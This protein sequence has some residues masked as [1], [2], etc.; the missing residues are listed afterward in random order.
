MNALAAEISAWPQIVVEV[1]IGAGGEDHCRKLGRAP[2][3]ARSG[4]GPI[5][6]CTPGKKRC[7]SSDV[8]ESAEVFVRRQV[9]VNTFQDM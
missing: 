2:R 6:K 7:Y 5:G 3:A 8:L 1:W 4:L 9:L